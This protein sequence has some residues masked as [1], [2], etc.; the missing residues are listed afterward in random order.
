[1]KTFVRT[2]I[3]A[4]LITLC[5]FI[6]TTTLRAETVKL[7]APNHASDLKSDLTSEIK[8]YVEAHELFLSDMGISAKAA[9][10]TVTVLSSRAEYDAYKG[11]NQMRSESPRGFYAHETQ[12]I[13][14]WETLNGGISTELRRILAHETFHHLLHVNLGHDL[15]LWLDEGLAVHFENAAKVS[16]NRLD[17]SGIHQGALSQV[18]KAQ[19]EK[20]FI[21]LATLLNLDRDSFYQN[22]PSRNYAESWSLVHFLLNDSSMRSKN[23]LGE[24]LRAL[25]AG[26]NVQAALTQA[27]G[28]SMGNLETAWTNHLARL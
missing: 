6:Q 12:T 19:G 25:A 9:D 21:P 23:A 10:L 7:D 8:E 16:G 28:M 2:C 22:N 5:G 26:A 11:Q 15:P 1:M 18:R 24:T 17:K 20:T 14:T 3:F 27:T 4:F 13:V